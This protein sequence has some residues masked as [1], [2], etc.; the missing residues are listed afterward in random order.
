VLDLCEDWLRE[1][2]AALGD[3]PKPSSLAAR[4]AAPSWS[5]RKSF[6]RSS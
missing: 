1:E 5:L 6:E 2:L 4:P 3:I